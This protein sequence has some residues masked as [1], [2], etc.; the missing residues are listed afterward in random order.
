MAEA[1]TAI[2]GI[3]RVAGSS[4]SCR[5]AVTPLMPGSWMSIRMRSGWSSCASRT[6][7][8]PVSASARRYPLNCRTSRTSLRFFSLS[9]T[10]RISSFAMTHREGERECRALA[11]LALHPDPPAVQFDELARQRQ[12]EPGALHLLGRRPHLPELLEHRLLVLGGDAYPSVGH[13]DLRH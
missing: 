4:R 9:S 11:H 8:S 7:S 6:P 10:I 2:A 5:S 13:G 1:V 12:P 3:R